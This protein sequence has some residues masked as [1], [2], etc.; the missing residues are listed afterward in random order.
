MNPHRHPH[1][2]GFNPAPRPVKIEH[3]STLLTGT[4]H[5]PVGALGVVLLAH[6]EA[7]A[8]RIP[9]NRYLADCLAIHQIGVLQVELVTPVEE[10]GRRGEFQEEHFGLMAERLANAAQWGHHQPYL[11]DYS[12]GYLGLGTGGT[13]ALMAAGGMTAAINAVAAMDAQPELAGDRLAYIQA[14]TLLVVSDTQDVRRRMNEVVFTR[15][16]C[17]KAL[18]MIPGTTALA[19]GEALEEVAILAAG[20]FQRHLQSRREVGLETL[21]VTP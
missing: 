3:H 14:A 18:K 13:V 19:T 10:T 12:L 1:Q 2:P 20:W 11:Q 9:R 17:E 15:L 4:L 16:R 6:A 7:G 8:H 21:G 5:L